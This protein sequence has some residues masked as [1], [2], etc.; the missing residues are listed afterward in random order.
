MKGIYLKFFTYEFQKHK[1]KLL[2]EWMLELA[3]KLGMP[4]GTV[5]RSIA[6]FGRHDIRQEHFFELASNVPVEIVFM[7]SEE[8]ALRFLQEL[9]KEK[10]DLVYIKIPA[11]Y[12]VLG[13]S[14]RTS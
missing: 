9:E 13:S 10:V 12:G 7:L 8:E 5:F 4:G 2:Y 11:E 14:E 3:K 6:G 1:H